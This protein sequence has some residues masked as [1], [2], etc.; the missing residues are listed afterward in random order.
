M[1]EAKKATET[2]FRQICEVAKKEVR[3]TLMFVHRSAEGGSHG[4]PFFA[5][6]NSAGEQT[7]GN[8]AAGSGSVVWKAAS[9]S[10]R[11]RWGVQ[12]ASANF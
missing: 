3:H 4:F 6:D 5:T 8:T 2:E 1:E 11:K 10:Q 9:Y 7:R 12:P